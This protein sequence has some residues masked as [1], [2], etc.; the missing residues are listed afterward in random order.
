MSAERRF[1]KEKVLEQ[2]AEDLHRK[3]VVLVEQ[4]HKGASEALF[5][6]AKEISDASKP[7]ATYTERIIGAVIPSSPRFPDLKVTHKSN[8]LSRS[9]RS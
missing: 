8:N 1:T 9:R 3:G 7:T 2:V 6:L 5:T 4:G